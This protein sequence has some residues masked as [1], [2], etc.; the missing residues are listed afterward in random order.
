MKTLDELIGKVDELLRLAK[1]NDEDHNL[2]LAAIDGNSAGTAIAI[3]E[4]RKDMLYQLEVL[5]LHP[6]LTRREGPQRESKRCP[7]KNTR[8]PGRNKRPKQS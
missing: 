5:S 6:G 8:V 7:A 4:L 1:Q 3:G 2:L